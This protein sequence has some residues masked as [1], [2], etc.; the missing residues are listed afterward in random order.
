VLAIN[1]PIKRIAAAPFPGDVHMC[2]RTLEQNQSVSQNAGR[3]FIIFAR[4]GA[5][6]R[7]R[8]RWRQRGF[9][10]SCRRSQGDGLSVF[11]Q[12]FR[13]AS[14]N[15]SPRAGDCRGVDGAVILR[16]SARGAARL[17][18]CISIPLSIL[19]GVTALWGLGRR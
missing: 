13:R 8:D 7:R 9:R 19:V 10:Y 16:F 17:I 14:L 12:R 11:D 5:I 15:A 6:R 2:T 4:A 3:K 1:I 18:I